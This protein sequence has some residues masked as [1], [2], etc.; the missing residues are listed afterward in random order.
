MYNFFISPQNLWRF[1]SNK[2]N[3]NNGYY[4]YINEQDNFRTLP[5]LILPLQLL[6]LLIIVVKHY[7]SYY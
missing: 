5:L 7:P 4:I 1:L 2:E 6:I 3:T